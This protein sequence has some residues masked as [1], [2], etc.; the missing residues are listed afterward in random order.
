[1]SEEET[2]AWTRGYLQGERTGFETSKRIID[3]LLEKYYPLIVFPS[4]STSAEG[5][6]IAGIRAFADNIKDEIDKKKVGNW[7][8]EQMPKEP[9]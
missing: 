6:T 2:K 8:V 4:T 5:S 1:M 3:D 9:T 7:K